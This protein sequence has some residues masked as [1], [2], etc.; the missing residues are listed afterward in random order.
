LRVG[1]EP[2]IFDQHASHRQI[3]GKLGLHVSR[4]LLWL[5]PILIFKI[6]SVP[7]LFRVRSLDV[8]LVALDA[9]SS[10]PNGS[11]NFAKTIYWKSLKHLSTLDMGVGN[12]YRSSH[13]PQLVCSLGGD[14]IQTAYVLA[15]VIALL[16][17]LSDSSD[18]YD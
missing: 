2:G 11:R 4:M 18:S 9:P 5:L 17:F 13:P 7:R 10:L 14:Y 6:C 3:V 8:K 12:C 16:S 15:C 1:W